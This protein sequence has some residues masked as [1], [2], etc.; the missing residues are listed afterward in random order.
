MK[1]TNVALLISILAL[2]LRIYMAY[3]GP[4]EYDEPI[5]VTIA[6]KYNLAMRQG[7]WK[8]IIESTDNIDSPPLHKVVYAIGLMLGRSVPKTGSMHSGMDLK[9]V[10]YW[11]KL[12][13]LR[14]I[15]VLLGTA[16]VYLISRINPLAGLFLAINTYAI[17]YTSVIYLEALPLLTSLAAIMAALKSLK[18]YQNSTT[19]WKKWGGWLALSSLFMGMTAA[20]KYIYC[21]VGIVILISTLIQGWKH[22]VSSLLGLAMWGLLTLAFFF[23][24]DPVLWHSPLSQLTKS[25]IFNF[26]YN[27]SQYV[28]EIGYPFWQP[29][30]WLMIS[31]PQQR[32]VPIAFFNN[33]GDYFISADSLIFVL[34]LVGLPALFQRNKPMFIWLIVGLAFLLLWDTKWP[35]YILVVLV[36]F[37]VSAAYGFDFMRFLPSQF[38]PKKK[39][40]IPQAFS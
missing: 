22:R 30:K 3:N 1:K 26:D 29:I 9:S 7:D 10:G 27:A 4:I 19:N 35:Q 39:D 23:L 6:A 18:A 13:I 2:F 16:T 21:L 17:K 11:P 32:N 31:I 12:L 40:A 36:P 37:C 28:R 14:L 34:A 33:P 20:S 15:A 25:V 38:K 8:Q 24:L 5:Y